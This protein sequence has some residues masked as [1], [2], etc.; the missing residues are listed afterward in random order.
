MIASLAVHVK[1]NAPFRLSL[2]VMIS[3]LSML[4]HALI[5]VLVQAFALLRLLRL[6]KSDDEKAGISPPFVLVRIPE[7]GISLRNEE[8]DYKDS[9]PML[10]MTFE[11]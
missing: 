5:A 4:M 9:S 10:R 11:N 3:M 8:P 7:Y 1:L 2:R 6:N